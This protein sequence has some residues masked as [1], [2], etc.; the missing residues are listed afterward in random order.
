VAY[1]LHFDLQRAPGKWVNPLSEYN[2]ADIRDGKI[3]PNPMFIKE[4]GKYVPNPNFDITYND[5][6]YTGINRDIKDDMKNP[7]SKLYKP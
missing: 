3:N 5:S 7:W 4:N 2:P 6:Y 1:H